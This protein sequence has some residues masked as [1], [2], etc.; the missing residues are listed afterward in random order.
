MSGKLFDRKYELQRHMETHGN[1]QYFCSAQACP[2]WGAKSFYRYDKLK[3]HMQKAHTQDT[4]FC[5]VVYGC[6]GILNSKDDLAAHAQYH[7]H[8]EKALTAETVKHLKACC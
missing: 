7:L 8:L 1:G 2:R 3:D 5:C 6:Y 4:A